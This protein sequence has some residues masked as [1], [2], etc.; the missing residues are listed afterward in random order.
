MVGKFTS[1][2]DIDYNLHENFHPLC[3][4]FKS[5]QERVREKGKQEEPFVCLQKEFSMQI[6]V[7]LRVMDLC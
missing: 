2:L 5:E 1:I 6:D 3:I 4:V 7:D